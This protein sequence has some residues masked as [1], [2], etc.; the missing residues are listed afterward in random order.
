MDPSH[1]PVSEPRP[2]VVACGCN[3]YAGP[4]GQLREQ[5]YGPIVESVEEARVGLGGLRYD[6]GLRVSFRG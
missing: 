1:T 4:Q 2:Q 6:A 3:R 5:G